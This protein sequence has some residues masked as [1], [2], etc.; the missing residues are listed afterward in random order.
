MSRIGDALKR[1]GTPAIADGLIDMPVVGAPANDAV[2]TPPPA[3]DLPLIGQAV[4]NES[5]ADADTATAL[6]RLLT[7]C[8]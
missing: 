7:A 6:V 2:V 4:A 3:D 8:C 1:A 5:P